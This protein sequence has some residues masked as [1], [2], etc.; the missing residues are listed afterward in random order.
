LRGP[1]AHG[2]FCGDD[3]AVVIPLPVGGS[4]LPDAATDAGSAKVVLDISPARDRSFRD[5]V[6]V[7]KHP[8]PP[9]PLKQSSA[10]EYHLYR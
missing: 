9:S 10:R 8:V 1:R 3:K 6:L 2:R 4:Q 7:R 5:F